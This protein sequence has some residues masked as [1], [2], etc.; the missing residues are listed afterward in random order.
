MQETGKKRLHAREGLKNGLVGTGG[1]SGPGPSRSDCRTPSEQMFRT[2][3]AERAQ[4]RTP[5]GMGTLGTTNSV[6]R[7]DYNDAHP[8]DAIHLQI[9]S[10]RCYVIQMTTSAIS[11]RSPIFFLADILPRLS[12]LGAAIVFISRL[13]FDP[14]STVFFPPSLVTFSAGLLQ[15]TFQ[16]FSASLFRCLI[17]F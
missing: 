12:I 10:N 7:L 14:L 4:P 6:G 9:K 15:H 11:N 5:R 17:S 2:G 3:S 8:G 13:D 1:H 16:R